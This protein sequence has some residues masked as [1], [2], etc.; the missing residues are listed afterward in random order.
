MEIG[1]ITEEDLGL[2]NYL[3]KEVPE[4]LAL[5]ERDYRTYSL[6]MLKALPSTKILVAHKVTALD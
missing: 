5:V 3:R 2:W 4:G 1:Q 6:D